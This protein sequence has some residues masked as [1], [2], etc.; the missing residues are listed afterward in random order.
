MLHRVYRN[1]T[2]I[3]FM[4]LAAANTVVSNNDSLLQVILTH[5]DDSNKVHALNA[6]SWDIKFNYPDSAIKLSIQALKISEE[7]RYKNEKWLTGISNSHRNLAIYHRL[8][9]NY[10]E[11]VSNNL[12]ALELLF[13]I[14]D[15]VGLAA[16]SSN[17]GLVFLNMGNYS[18]AL[19]YFYD[20]LR[21]SEKLQNQNHIAAILGNIG[22][23]YYYQM[24]YPK[25][26]LYYNRAFDIA[27]EMKDQNRAAIQ[28]VNIALCYAELSKEKT[29]T[30]IALNLFEKS[31]NNYRLAIK[32]DPDNKI[33]LA[34]IYGNIGSG[35]FE[36]SKSIEKHP[37]QSAGLID[38]AFFY[39]TKALELREE[40]RSV[41]L[42]TSVLGNLANLHTLKGNYSEAEKLLKRAIVISDSIQALSYLKEQYQYLKELYL[43]KN[44]PEK[45]LTAYKQFIIIRDSLFNND[46]TKK[47]I[48]LELE[49][50]FE[51][52][53]AI[54]KEQNEAA[55]LVAAKENERQKLFLI[56]ISAVALGLVIIA[57]A[58]FRSL[59]LTRKQKK[60]I[61]NQKMIVEEKQKEIL[62]S[63]HY[64]K[65][66]QKSLLPTER[67]IEKELNRLI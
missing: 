13:R 66:I 61:E 47:L 1:I 21:I 45:A 31:I 43:K 56:F 64:A 50:E 26:I 22:L 15:S 63:I 53:E 59:K 55:A 44:E 11:A 46:Q 16:V 10:P 39:F 30:I 19:N 6:L 34:S 52:K 35:Y 51:K 20:A 58:I 28:L 18:R 62:D 24:D 12:N 36:R 49:Y 23:V 57:A 33:L 65:R 25:S 8:K 14:Q 7:I 48:Q 60:I 27:R 32:E 67:Y 41:N 5:D 3:L 17:L 54:L 2:L 4:L 38:S 9:G 42:I 37:Y 40:L 29:D